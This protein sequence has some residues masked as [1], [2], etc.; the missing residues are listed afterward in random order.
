MRRCLSRLPQRVGF[1]IACALLGVGSLGFAPPQITDS[2]QPTAGFTEADVSDLRDFPPA[3]QLTARNALIMDA[4]TGH[5]VWG[6]REHEHIAPASTTKIMTALV[7]LERGDLKDTITVRYEYIKSLEGTG[8]SLMGLVVGDTVTLEDLL[9]GLLL[10]SGNDAALVIAQMI[11][12]STDQFVALMNQKAAALGLKDTHFS[13]PHGL[14]ADDH[15]TSAFDLAEMGRVALRNPL[16]ARIVSSP[17]AVR[18]ASRQFLLG[19]TNRLLS[20]PEI[21]PGVNGIKT[22]ST[23]RAGDSIIASATR[24]GRTVIVAAMGT[25]GRDPDV[26]KLLDL[27]FKSY[28]WV[29]IP[30]P[31]FVQAPLATTSGPPQMPPRQVMVA[32]WDADRWSIAR[33]VGDGAAMAFRYL[34]PDGWSTLVRLGGS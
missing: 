17:R 1:A 32:P 31:V 29:P 28:R 16:F 30:S 25:R 22:G 2:A 24:D 4:E 11:A 19:N 6:Y 12:G 10:P 14:D 7:A 5:V 20:E 8:S 3:P 23:E 33:A 9:Y 21:A 34:L 18:T 15:Y 27:A 13:N 26:V